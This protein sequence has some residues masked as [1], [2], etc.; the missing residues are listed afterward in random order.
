VDRRRGVVTLSMTTLMIVVRGKSA[1][2]DA[3]AGSKS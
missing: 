2:P 3:S 1:G